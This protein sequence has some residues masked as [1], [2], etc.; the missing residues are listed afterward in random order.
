M[1]VLVHMYYEKRIYKLISEKETTLSELLAQTDIS[2]KSVVI[3]SG[4][5]GESN[6]TP[7]VNLTK[8]L[9]DYNMWFLE[10][11]YVAELSVFKETD[12]Y[13]RKLYAMYLGS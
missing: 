13:D 2:E 7:M 1:G 6:Q 4:R 10:K 9:V 8:T 3:F 12:N 11:D 5:F